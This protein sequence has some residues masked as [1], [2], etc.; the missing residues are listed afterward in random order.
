MSKG[1]KQRPT[2]AQAFGT[3]YDVVFGKKDEFGKRGFINP[4]LPLPSKVVMN[5]DW[6]EAAKTF[7]EGRP[8]FVILHSTGEAGSLGLPDSVKAIYSEK[9]PPFIGTCGNCKHWERYEPASKNTLAAQD[10]N[11]EKNGVC[12]GVDRFV[13]HCGCGG[14]FHP[15]ETFSCNMW[16]AADALEGKPCS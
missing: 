16:Q 11:W 13:D 4:P 1:S 7:I 6:M 8:Y 5:E 15:P 14:G 2:D 12:S 10:P 3:S 9:L